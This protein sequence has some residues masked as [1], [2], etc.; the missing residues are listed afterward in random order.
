M[1]IFVMRVVF[2]HNRNEQFLSVQ[3]FIFMF[4]E[5]EWSKLSRSLHAQLRSNRAV[6]DRTI[7]A[8]S[9]RSS[10][11]P[12]SSTVFNRS[13]LPSI[14][15]RRKMLSLSLYRAQSW[16][17]FSNPLVNGLRMYTI[18]MSPPRV[19][20]TTLWIHSKYIS[21]ASRAFSYPLS[22]VFLFHPVLSLD[23]FE[24]HSIQASENFIFRPQVTSY[25]KYVTAD[26]KILY[27]YRKWRN[28]RLSRKTS[29]STSKTSF[30]DLK[31]PHPKIRHCLPRVS[32]S[33]G[34]DLILEKRQLLLWGPHFWPHVTSYP[35]YVTA[36]LES[37]FCTE[38]ILHT[39]NA[40]SPRKIF[41]SERKWR[42][43]RNRA[44][45]VEKLTF[46]PE[47]TSRRK[48]TTSGREIWL[49]HR[50]YVFLEIHH[51]SRFGNLIFKFHCQ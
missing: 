32:F 46:Q 37:P 36:D 43:A 35:K 20:S 1:F 2:F 15:A 17:P 48:C 4:T 39:K 51:F 29:I 8:E 9:R 34:S 27:F 30:F 5:P 18:T 13:Q 11:Y 23:T 25:R 42:H 49:I 50:T 14:S 40:D 47:V 28:R 38:V 12:F 31:W 26:L 33:N 7:V 16:S 22:C 41:F 21:D 24:L 10:R 6:Q 19:H 3:I 44:V 45:P